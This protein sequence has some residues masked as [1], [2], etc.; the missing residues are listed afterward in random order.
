MGPDSE[1]RVAVLP[2]SGLDKEAGEASRQLALLLEERG[3][4][5]VCPVRFQ[6]SPGRYEKDLA[7]RDLVVIDGCGTGCA[8]RLAGEK[9]L[10]P[11]STVR[12]GE[13]L[14]KR[15]VKP[16]R[17]P[18][19]GEAAARELP[20]I[21]DEI[22][23][24]CA[25]RPEQA[26]GA[27]ETTGG[28]KAGF[29][30]PVDYLEFSVGKYV[31]RVPAAGYLFNENDCWARVEG[32]RARVGISDYVQ[33]SIAD[34]VLFEPPALGA[35]LSMFDEAGSLETTKTAVD[36]ITPVSGKVVAVNREAEDAP[37]L[38]NAD[39]YE[40]GWAVELEL[41]DLEAERGL[42][43]DA[44]GYFEYLQAKVTAEHER[45]GGERADE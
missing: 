10:K 45:L 35:E 20:S 14:E 1:F 28:A 38:M 24:S 19:L 36:I 32:A 6:R 37:E 3:A 30:E 33:Q 8:G 21:A 15:G 23:A 16:G 17:R 11:A 39:P 12:L 40:R 43:M 44:P 4:R 41:A 29:D 18:R 2:C 34:V 42:L 13:L 27:A 31:F 9:G 26:Q 5:V 22:E 7:G 25:R